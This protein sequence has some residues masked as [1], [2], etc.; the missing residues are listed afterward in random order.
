[1]AVRRIAARS[2]RRRAG[3][4]VSASTGRIGRPVSSTRPW[5]TL[6]R[7]SDSGRNLHEHRRAVGPSCP[8]PVAG[9]VTGA[10]AV[11]YLGEADVG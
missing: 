5:A 7:L 1:M 9:A 3:E 6:H 11:R 8:R 10:V 4:P 2:L